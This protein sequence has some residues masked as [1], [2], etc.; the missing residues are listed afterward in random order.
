MKRFFTLCMALLFAGS[1]FAQEVKQEEKKGPEF[2]YS[3]YGIAYGVSGGQKDYKYDYSHVRVRPYFT[4]GEENVKLVTRLEI[5]QDFG[6]KYSS[7]MANDDAY[8]DNGTDNK[9]VEVKWAFLEMKDVVLP[10]LTLMGGLNGWKIPLVVDN[11]NAMFQAS[12]D[13]GMGKAILGYVNHEENGYVSKNYNSTT[14]TATDN[15]D[16]VLSYV[17]QLPVK[18]A[19]I[20]IT[21]AAVFT[22]MGKNGTEITDAVA[23][24]SYLYRFF[25]GSLNV[26]ALN[27][28][29]AMGDLS[30]TAAFAYSK[31]K[32]KI[33]DNTGAVGDSDLTTAE[34]VDIKTMAFD[35]GINY[36]VNDMF[37]AGLFYT[38][39]SGEKE[40]EE[41][42][43]GHMAIM[44]KVYGAPDGRLFILDSAGVQAAGGHDEFDMG[45]DASGLNI[46][47]INAEVSI[48]KAKLFAQ[49]AYVTLN[50]EVTNGEG[51]KVKNLGQE[52]DLKLSYNVTSKASLFLEYGYV[53]AGDD[54]GFGKYDKA[55]NVSQLAWGMTANI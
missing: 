34:D 49:Y 31:G 46:Y 9:V 11:D 45:E 39:Y 27:A 40:N 29:G 28:A 13:F 41:D 36:K 7:A 37:K 47:G 15:K 10:G 3:I 50:K 14:D 19:D 43:K 42:M 17:F 20:T 22:K 53:V 18:V 32:V 35:A 21:P 1:A 12:F 52:I 30:F 8:A 54:M 26:Y 51:K 4:L 44:E 55:E 33:D 48:E 25:D 6:A 5:D 16:D 38:M 23:P 2:K 24:T